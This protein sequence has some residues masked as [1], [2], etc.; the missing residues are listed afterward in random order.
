MEAYNGF[1][2]RQRQRAQ[3]WLNREWKSGRLE[4]PTRCVA[5]G[6]TEGGIQAH[7]EDYSE[8]FR[9]GVTD[10]F[11]LCKACH[12]MVHF[13]SRNPKAWSEYRAKIEAGAR[14]KI[15][16][17]RSTGSDLFEWGSPPTRF[18]LLEIERSQDEVARRLARQETPE[19]GAA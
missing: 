5:C 11:H 8:P 17:K 2:G 12:H 7:A 6:Q 1:S 13:R 19:Q 9:A 18:A 15:P 10:E 14:K 3:D 4:E 16:S